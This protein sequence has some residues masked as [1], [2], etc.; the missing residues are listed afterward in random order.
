MR[1]R[2]V[3]TRK[4]ILDLLELHLAALRNIPGAV[5]RVLV[6][7]EKLHHLGPAFDKELRRGEAHPVWIRH[8]LASLDA[9]QDFVRLDIVMCEV[10]R[11]VG[12]QQGD[13]GIGRHAPDLGNQNFVLIEPVVLQF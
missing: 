11:V 8:S 5:E 3:E 1:L 2:H 7:G 6:A 13:T 9:K 10:V 4:W 12:D